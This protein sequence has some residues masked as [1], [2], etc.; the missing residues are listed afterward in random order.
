MAD[1]KTRNLGANIQPFSVDTSCIKNFRDIGSTGAFA[2]WTNSRLI[3]DIKNNNYHNSFSF[4]YRKYYALLYQKAAVSNGE[5]KTVNHVMS[6]CL[7]VVRCPAFVFRVVSSTAT[8]VGTQVNVSC[9]AGQKLQTGHSM[10]RTLCSRS[11][12]WAPSVPECVGEQ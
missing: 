3:T 11:G 5:K 10:T 4:V 8:S 2:A 7:A 1:R 12:D 9:L 6:G